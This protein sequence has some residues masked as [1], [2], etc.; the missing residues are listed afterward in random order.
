MRLYF[1]AL[2]LLS[3]CLASNGSEP[4]TDHELTSVKGMFETNRWCIPFGSTSN[5]QFTIPAGYGSN[6]GEG[7]GLPCMF[8]SQG[9]PCFV[10]TAGPGKHDICDIANDA[11]KKCKYDEGWCRQ[12]QAGVVG[13]CSNGGRMCVIATNAQVVNNG[14]REFCKELLSKV[15]DDR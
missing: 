6:T 1:F 7:Q 2:I 11:S 9:D 13:N 5:C 12:Y 15:V 4:A 14:T 3:S 10:W 8:Y